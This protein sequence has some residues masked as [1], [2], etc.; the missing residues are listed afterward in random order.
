MK[1]NLFVA[2]VVA[3][4]VLSMLGGVYEV[5]VA[6]AWTNRQVSTPSLN[7]VLGAIDQGNSYLSRLYF[8][9]AG[10]DEWGYVHGFLVPTLKVL[11]YEKGWML[12][13]EYEG[14]VYPKEKTPIPTIIEETPLE[15]HNNEFSKHVVDWVFPFALDGNGDP[16]YYIKVRLTVEHWDICER[17]KVDVLEVV[18]S[19]ISSHYNVYLNNIKTHTDVYPSSYGDQWVQNF[20]SGDWSDL[21]GYRFLI[22]GDQATA[23]GAFQWDSENYGDIIDHI[24]EGRDDFQYTADK[25]FAP[26]GLA[27]DRSDPWYYMVPN[28]TLWLP[29]GYSSEVLYHDAYT[30]GEPFG[31]YPI[32]LND[33]S[34]VLQLYF[35]E[36]SGAVAH[37]ASTNGNDGSVN[38]AS[39]TSNAGIGVTDCL[40]FS[41]DYVE[42]PNSNS[43]NPNQVSI[44]AWVNPFTTQ[45]AR[46]IVSKSGGA[47]NQYQ[48]YIY[49]GYY[50]FDIKTNNGDFGITSNCQ[51]QTWA[52][53][54]FAATYDGSMMRMYVNGVLVASGS[55]SGN[56]IS[57]NQPVYVGMWGGGGQYFQGL[58]DEPYVFNRGLTQKEVKQIYGLV[59]GG[60]YGYQPYRSGVS[61][62]PALWNSVEY[63]L[64]SNLWAYEAAHWE[65]IYGGDIPSGV[66][67]NVDNRLLVDIDTLLSMCGYDGYG[68]TGGTFAY[69]NYLSGH[70]ATY[71][72]ANYLAAVT[73]RAYYTDDSDLWAQ[74]D[75]IA[76][77]LVYRLR[78]SGAEMYSTTM[79]GHFYCASQIGAFYNAYDHS[80]SSNFYPEAG[81]RSFL[82]DIL[83]DYFGTS[84]QAHETENPLIN[85]AGAVEVTGLCV[86]A[87]AVYAHFK[88]DW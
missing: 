85:A 78:V 62:N 83:E 24:V 86:N 32:L 76:S 2:V 12:C 65:W 5:R 17:I 35:N 9:V 55:A 19:G 13:G 3:I 38:G 10:H 80:G 84:T 6:N 42:V 29:S 25:Y 1:K 22:R 67:H 87:L 77:D 41:D 15:D 73:M 50:H 44:V 33:S 36:G 81:G 39:W 23:L 49:D 68:I 63:Q 75:Q 43:L 56:V 54:L 7:D 60:S 48:T 26:N 47:T 45:N 59:D 61:I 64:E 74:A 37:D 58:I 79:D 21:Q 4:A 31:W 28:P 69:A 72:L 57:Y 8:T 51:A 16:L 11:N 70:Y 20:Y 82:E 71:R 14:F 88:Y 27:A 46:R 66:R 53:S 52:W 18:G 40:S 30:F 34:A